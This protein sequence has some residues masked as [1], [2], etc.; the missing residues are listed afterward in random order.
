MT[1]TTT[2]TMT[3]T[4]IDLL[5]RNIDKTPDE[6]VDAISKPFS[7]W[8][9]GSTLTED[10]YRQYGNTRIVLLST[11][12]TLRPELAETNTHTIRQS[13]FGS[14][15]TFRHWQGWLGQDFYFRS[16]ESYDAHTSECPERPR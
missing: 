13:D 3:R 11:A 1:T 2:R 6:I 16:Q 8:R 10:E 5:N 14:N 4:L 9:L 15:W 12:Y 7:K